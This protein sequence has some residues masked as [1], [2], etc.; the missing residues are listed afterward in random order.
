MTN[1]N[2]LTRA[3]GTVNQV[4]RVHKSNADAHGQA[5]QEFA[6]DGN[7]LPVSPQ[8]E[9]DADARR[10]ELNEAMRDVSDYVQTI[11]RELNFSIDEAYGSTIVTVIDQLSGEVVRQIPSQD[12]LELARN[13]EA[14]K[15]ADMKGLLFEGDA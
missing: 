11:S 10:K 8:Q 2:K 3:G 7:D 12:M 14:L 13:L 1:L 6:G 15:E 9:I 5:R 4:S